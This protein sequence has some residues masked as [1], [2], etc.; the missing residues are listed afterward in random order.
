MNDP[1]L[2]PSETEPVLSVID[3]G[4]C[5]AAEAQA[6]DLAAARA[7]ATGQRGPVLRFYQ[8]RPAALLGR[9][10]WPEKELRLD[11][12]RDHG[13]AVIRR[14]SGGGAHHL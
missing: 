13:I 14:S 7:V 5:R 12:C 9:H 1:G 6:R 3:G 11:Y 2:L 4:L 8:C 10:Q